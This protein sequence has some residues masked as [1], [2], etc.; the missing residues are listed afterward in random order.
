MAKPEKVFKCQN[1]SVSVFPADKGPRTAQI[2]VAYKSGD[3]W[4]Y[5]TSLGAKDLIVAANLLNKAA[6]YI[7]DAES[8]DAPRSFGGQKKSN[9]QRERKT[10]RERDDDSVPA[11]VI[12]D[13]DDGE[14]IPF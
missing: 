8:K 1:V 2:S 4:K 7:M 12:G 5:S 3:E 11:G 13:G 9:Q 14:D 6:D 10:A